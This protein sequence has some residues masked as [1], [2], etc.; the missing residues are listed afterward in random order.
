MTMDATEREPFNGD[1]IRNPDRIPVICAALEERWNEAPDMRLG[2]LLWT[3]YNGDDP[4]HIA[5]SHIADQLGTEIPSPYWV[6]HNTTE[7]EPMSDTNDDIDID[8]LSERVIET[9][10]AKADTYQSKTTDYGESWY[11]IG[12]LLYQMA[13]KE[14]VTLE[15]PEDWV[16]V[17]LYTRR[18]DKLARAFNG[19]FMGTE[20]SYE[21]IVDA[22]ADEGSYADM[23]AG[24][25]SMIADDDTDDA[26]T[27]TDDD[28]TKGIDIPES[29]AV[30]ALDG[31]DK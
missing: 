25:A 29:A 7:T 5:D 27:D 10:D 18:L 28:E 4:F 13:H 9:M 12:E 15:S 19:E 8:E 3:F 2:Q 1:A 16:R 17:G 6:D 21:P 24:V 20:L 31:D 14:S 23:H 30:S 11:I 22:H 26:D